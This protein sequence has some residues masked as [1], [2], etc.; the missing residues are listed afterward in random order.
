MRKKK[1]LI[2][3][4]AEIL[5]LQAFADCNP[6]ST[7]YVKQIQHELE[8]KIINIPQGPRG[9]QG[10]SGPQGVAG[11]AGPMGP[12]GPAG[13]DGATGPAGPVGPTGADGAAGPAGQDAPVYTLC[14]ETMGGI[15]F[16]VNGDGSH[17]LI[18]AKSDQSSAINWSLSAGSTLIS[19]ARG[20]GIGAGQSNTTLIVAREVALINTLS[21]ATFLD[22]AARSCHE[23][24]IQGNGTSACTSP[25]NA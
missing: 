14:Q 6:A 9:I 5:S 22:F 19:G 2:L 21:L 10:I 11:V 8:S 17:G 24:A 23:Y 4:V 16:W 15:V 25:G 13:A 7:C 1:L 3:I 12:V 20:D 18:A